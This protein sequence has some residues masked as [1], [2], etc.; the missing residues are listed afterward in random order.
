MNLDILEHAS[1]FAISFGSLFPLV[2]PIG[3]AFIVQ[4]FFSR[5]SFEQRKKMVLVVVFNSLVLG[6][7]TIFLGS[8]CLKLMGVSTVVTQFAGGILI[9]RMG[10]G[11]LDSKEQKSDNSASQSEDVSQSLFYPIAFPLT[12][13]PGAISA[14]ITLS[15]HAHAD[16]F[17]QTSWRMATIGLALGVVLVISY[18]CYVYADVL[19]KKIG[20]T[21]SN[22]LSRLMSFLVFCIGLQMAISGVKHLFPELLK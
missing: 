10:L 4:N 7:G 17:I 16:D 8:W 1:L 12:V 3:T 14:L 22:V 20:P 11:M 6:S 5:V 15:A 21:G 13:G 9:A 19:I 2:N 18:F